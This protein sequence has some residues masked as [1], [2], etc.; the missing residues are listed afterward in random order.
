MFCPEDQTPLALADWSGHPIHRCPQ[1][2]GVALPGT[3]LREVRAFAALELHKQQDHTAHALACPVDG[4]MMKELA[5]KDVA[6]CA[7]P[8]CYGLW[9]DAQHMPRLAALVAPS[10]TPD[11]SK[12]G[13][14]LGTL[15]DAGPGSRVLGVL[16]VLGHG[17]GAIAP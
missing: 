5:Y 8:Q 15:N 14:S 4:K 7:C 3:L 13:Q 2:E 1:C 11:L 9:L 10:G 12:I 17:P 16:G 6:L